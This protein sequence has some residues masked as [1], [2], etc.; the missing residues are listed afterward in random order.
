[1]KENK[2]K[3]TKVIK[4]IDTFCY[5]IPSND[6]PVLPRGGSG[7]LDIIEKYK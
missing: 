1:V 2:T 3:F 7:Y 6:F 5:S 4:E